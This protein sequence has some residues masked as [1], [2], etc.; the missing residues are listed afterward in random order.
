MVGNFVKVL[1]LIDETK[2]GVIQLLVISEKQEDEEKQ[3]LGSSSTEAES[4]EV[5]Q[6]ESYKIGKDDAN[7]FHY[8]LASVDSKIQ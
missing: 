1:E 2:E 6:T 7:H 4:L 5:F 8:V 3:H